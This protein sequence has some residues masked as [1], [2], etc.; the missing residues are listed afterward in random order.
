MDK[1][2]DAIFE[3]PNFFV[4]RTT[5]DEVVTARGS[6]LVSAGAIKEADRKVFEKLLGKQAN[7]M[8]T[9]L[10]GTA[11][12]SMI[13]RR[14]LF[15]QDLIAKKSNELIA[16]GKNL[17]LLKLQTKQDYCLVMTFNK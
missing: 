2:S 3:V 14:N 12:L 17:C 1:P 10:G 5:L 9:I 15:F 6:A 8:Q 13:T 11:K 16:N 4:N 7:P